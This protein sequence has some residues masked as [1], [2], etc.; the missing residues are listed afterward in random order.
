[1]RTSVWWNQ[2]GVYK[3]TSSCLALVTT[4][5]TSVMFWLD[6]WPYAFLRWECSPYAFIWTSLVM[7]PSMMVTAPPYWVKP[8]NPPDFGFYLVCAKVSPSHDSLCVAFSQIPTCVGCLCL[9]IMPRPCL[10][11]E[12][13]VCVFGVCCGIRPA[14]FLVSRVCMERKSSGTMHHLYWSVKLQIP[15]YPVY[16]AMCVFG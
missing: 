1:M 8:I 15:V 14:V 11:P 13:R 16:H 4:S 6:C 2:I 7:S 3:D 5:E 9:C 10:L 12:W